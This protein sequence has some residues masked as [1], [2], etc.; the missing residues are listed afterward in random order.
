MADIS[1]VLAQAE[2]VDN[3][4]TATVRMLL[5]QDLARQHADLETE[6]EQAIVGDRN[7]NRT[8]VAPTIAAQIV[9]L[10]R[11]MDEAKVAFT[12]RAMGRRDWVEL[13][14]A[15]PP[16]KA[17]LTAV[18]AMSLD[19][20]KRPGLD[21]NPDTFPV[22]AV[23]KSCINPAMSLDDAKKLERAITDSQWAQLWDAAIRVN[24]GSTDP[25]ASRA[26]GLILRLKERSESTAAP[27]ESDDPS[28]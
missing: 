12:F 26:A 15:H 7:E 24:V 21:F 1:D 17:Q 28:S 6:L 11:Q 18:A 4:P 14:A 5:R 3:R 23:A 2:D 8:P 20:L 25:K 16:T 19:P 22:A 27:E 10:E 13:V 9:D